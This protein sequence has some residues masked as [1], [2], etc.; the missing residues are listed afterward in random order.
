MKPAIRVS[1]EL[2]EGCKETSSQSS[3][4]QEDEKEFFR[5]TAE[6]PKQERSGVYTA[7]RDKENHNTGNVSPRGGCASHPTATSEKGG[8]EI[9]VLVEDA[10]SHVPIP[11]SKAT[12][13]TTHRGGGREFLRIWSGT[14]RGKMNR[15]PIPVASFREKNRLTKETGK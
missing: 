6:W 9:H 1:L 3:L 13:K 14:P 15:Q 7:G 5:R 4:R 8:P 11:T 10:Q 2:T 12:V